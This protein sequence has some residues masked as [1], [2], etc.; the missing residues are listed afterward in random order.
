MPLPLPP[1]LVDS[2]WYFEV[3][4]KTPVIKILEPTFSQRDLQETLLENNFLLGIT[5][6]DGSVESNCNDFFT[7][8]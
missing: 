1:I 3:V 8:L 5:Q 6:P 2:P 4:I 7:H